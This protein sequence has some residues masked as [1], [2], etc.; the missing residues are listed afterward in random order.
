MENLTR[1]GLVVCEAGCCLHRTEAN[2]VD[3]SL[4]VFEV[5]DIHLM[6]I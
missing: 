4:Y 2:Q 1:Q 3:V 6:R 5:K